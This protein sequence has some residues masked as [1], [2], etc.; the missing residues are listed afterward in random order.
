M[1]EPVPSEWIDWKK[2]KA[3]MLVRHEARHRWAQVLWD[4]RKVQFHSG[5]PGQVLVWMLE[6]YRPMPV[7]AGGTDTWGIEEISMVV[8]LGKVIG[9]NTALIERLKREEDEFYAGLRRGRVHDRGSDDAC[10]P[11]EV[12]EVQAGVRRQGCDPGAHA[13]ELLLLEVPLAADPTPG[14]P[15][16]G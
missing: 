4:T 14:L 6:A 15:G 3:G 9:Q 16:L 11:G 10:D 5:Q 1:G 8:H 7:P 13:G 2:I 12:P